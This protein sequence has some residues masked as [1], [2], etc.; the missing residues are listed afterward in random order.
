LPAIVFG[1]EDAHPPVARPVGMHFGSERVIS[2]GPGA[3]LPM[4]RYAFVVMAVSVGSGLPF[5]SK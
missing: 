3:R 2:T 4:S 5:L 1:F